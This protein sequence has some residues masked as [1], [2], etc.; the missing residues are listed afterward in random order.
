MRVRERQRQREGEREKRERERENQAE[1]TRYLI[2][3]FYLI[4]ISFCSESLFNFFPAF[5]FG[6]DD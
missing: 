5:I 6:G 1:M 4:G 3:L 2:F